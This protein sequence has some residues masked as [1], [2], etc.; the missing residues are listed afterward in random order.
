MRPTAPAAL[1]AEIESCGRHDAGSGERY[2]EE[3]I[4]ES[5]ALLRADTFRSGLSFFG[6]AQRDAV[7]ILQRRPDAPVANRRTSASWSPEIPRARSTAAPLQGSTTR[8]RMRL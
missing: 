6:D 1:V 5:C 8:P 2:C 7:L 3:H 4:T